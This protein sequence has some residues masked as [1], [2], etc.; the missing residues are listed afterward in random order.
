MKTKPLNF[1]ELATKQNHGTFPYPHVLLSLDPGET[2]GYAIFDTGALKMVGQ[3]DTADIGKSVEQISYLI[4]T[5]KPA[6]VVYEDYK[7]YGWK[8]DAHSWASLHTPQL[9]GCI[10]TVCTMLSK[11]THS[12]M[13]QQAKGFC[14]DDKL[15]DWDMYPK[16]LKHARDAIRHGCYYMLFNHHKVAHKLLPES[17]QII[18]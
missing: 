18:T 12:Q 6:V 17:P 5:W 9:I 3:L 10:L 2:T 8:A 16:G 4:N 7:V 13:A 11:P 1:I 15:K 14:T